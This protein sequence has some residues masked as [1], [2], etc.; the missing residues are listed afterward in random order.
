M[1]D[2]IHLN[3]IGIDINAIA[4][5]ILNIKCVVVNLN[6]PLSDHLIC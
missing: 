2:P 3:D 1:K 4:F 6:F 5:R